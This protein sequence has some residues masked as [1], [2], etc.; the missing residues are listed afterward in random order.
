MLRKPASSAYSRPELKNLP[1]GQTEAFPILR[2]RRW[3]SRT[4]HCSRLFSRNSKDREHNH[5]ALSAGR[6]K[7]DAGT[8]SRLQIWLSR[9]VEKTFPEFVAAQFGKVEG[10]CWSVVDL[11]SH[12]TEF[13]RCLQILFS[14]EV[15]HVRISR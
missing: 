4:R 5:R 11:Q 1:S 15:S 9:K 8:I 13:G 12:G 3:R 6:D 14:H 10:R 2:A 7:D